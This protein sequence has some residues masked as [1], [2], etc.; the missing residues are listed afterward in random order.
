VC[1]AAPGGGGKAAAALGD[2]LQAPAGGFGVVE[3]P[4]RPSRRSGRLLNRQVQPHH[5]S[6]R[7]DTHEE[8][9]SE[10]IAAFLP[11]VQ[12][13]VDQMISVRGM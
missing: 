4:Q 1:Q 10:T 11:K 9:N 7:H 6:R 13:A 5:H 3:V 12:K 2:Q 8:P